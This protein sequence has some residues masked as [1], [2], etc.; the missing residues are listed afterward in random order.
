M[1]SPKAG[2]SPK[3]QMEM[4]MTSTVDQIKADV[5]T[6]AAKF[7]SGAWGPFR[8]YLALYP[9]RCFW[10]ALVAGIIIGRLSGLA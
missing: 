2:N 3:P 8:R 1:N 4:H 7:N 9:L 6:L 10:G 5:E